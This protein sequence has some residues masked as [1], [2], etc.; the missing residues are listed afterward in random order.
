M[1]LILLFGM[2]MYILCP[3]ILEVCSL[4]FAFDFTRGY[5]EEIA[6]SLKRD[7]GLLNSLKS[8]KDYGGF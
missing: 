7:F 4:L 1:P 8:V 5:S 2:I 3:Y 6:L